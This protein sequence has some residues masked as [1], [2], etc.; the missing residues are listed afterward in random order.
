MRDRGARKVLDLGSGFGRW[1]NF[2]AQEFGATVVG[3]DYALGGCLLG[4][5]LCQPGAEA[6]FSTGDMTRLPFRDDAF[7]GFVAVLILDNVE[8]AHG[9][10]AVRELNRVLQPGSPGF[11][12]HNPWP[13]PSAAETSGN[14]TASCSRHDWSDDEALEGLLGSWRVESWG[15]DEHELRWFLVG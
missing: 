4:Q 6:L 2:V 8:K 12:V 1:T 14:P 13:M 15:R 7:D 9:V 5:E 3:V 11:V 10:A